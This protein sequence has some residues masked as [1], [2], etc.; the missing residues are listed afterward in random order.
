MGHRCRKPIPTGGKCI[1]QGIGAPD[2]GW[3]RG[4]M[5]VLVCGGRD[6]NDQSAAWGFLDGYR[7]RISLLISGGARG[8]DTLA[9]RWAANNRIDTEIF[10][11]D[12]NTHGRKA[13][14]LRNKQMLDEGRPDVVIAFPGGRGTAMMKQLARDAGVPVI[15]AGGGER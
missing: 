11:A 5:K 1:F 13:G 3:R 12:W 7:A 15:E 9:E 14:F 4:E 2:E 6:Y 8:A 10:R